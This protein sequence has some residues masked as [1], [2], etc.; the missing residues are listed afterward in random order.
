MTTLPNKN[1]AQVAAQIA[2]TNAALATWRD[3]RAQSAAEEGVE[4]RTFTDPEW[5]EEHLRIRIKPDLWRQVEPGGRAPETIAPLRYSGV[6]RK[7][8]DALD[9]MRAEEGRALL[10]I[11][12]ARQMGVSTWIASRM[13]ARAARGDGIGCLMVGCDEENVMHLWSMHQMFL[14]YAPHPPTD[15]TNRKEIVYSSPHHS[16]VAVQIAGGKTGTGRTLRFLHASEKAK[17]MNAVATDTALMQAA[18]AADVVVESTANGH[19]GIGKPF[20]DEWQSAV[21]GKSDYFP[22][23]FGWHEDE[24]Y[25]IPEESPWFGRMMD[26]PITDEEGAL[27]EKHDLTLSQVAW[28]RWAIRNLCRGDATIFRQEY[29]ASDGEAFQ[30]VEGTRVFSIR[31]CSVAHAQAREPLTVG[32][33]LWQVEPRFDSSG[34]CQNQTELRVRFQGDESGP[35]KVWQPPPERR[36]DPHEYRF[37]GAADVA[38][39]VKGGDLNCCPIL[40]RRQRKIVARWTELCDASLFGTSCSMLA[41]WYGA[42]VAPE[43]NDAGQSVLDKM[44]DTVGPD[45][46]WNA[47]Q[48]HLGVVDDVLTKNAYGW[49]T[50]PHNHEQMVQALVDVVRERLWV[51]PDDAFWSEAMGCVREPSGKAHITG[52]DRVA[53]SCILAMM[54]RLMPALSADLP[55]TVGRDYGGLDWRS[56]RQVRPKDPTPRYTA[57]YSGIDWR[58]AG[59]SGGSDPDVDDPDDIFD[60]DE[61]EDG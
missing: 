14:Q 22:L 60:E 42:Q 28:R 61:E 24:R 16:L 19:V 3:L 17:W 39:G 40:D 47:H 49:R 2:S 5:A 32:R 23:F 11:L 43:V 55:V 6:Q 12:K 10:I 1:P 29:P 53:S 45:Y 13:F 52:L 4:S 41:L 54:D 8:N 31:A 58:T 26:S 57:D 30:R 7:L 9:G 59:L 33:L 38:R 15:Y 37:A 20:Y 50:G 56:N 44:Y 21:N 36:P 35:L 34:T 18:E 48:F 51:D 25:A 46:L 27:K